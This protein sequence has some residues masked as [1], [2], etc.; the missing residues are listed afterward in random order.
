VDEAFDHKGGFNHGPSPF[1]YLL[2]ALGASTAHTIRKHADTQKWKLE[3]TIV[4]VSHKRMHARDL[5]Q[6]L[7]K[8]QNPSSKVDYYDR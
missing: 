5:D 3:K 6:P 8:N 4:S 7:E 2:G 1:D